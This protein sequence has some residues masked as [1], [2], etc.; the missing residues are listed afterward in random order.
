MTF[1]LGFSILMALK[2]VLFFV[3]IYIFIPS[4]IVRFRDEETF[5][6]KFFISLV[7]SSVI[8]IIIVHIL[9]FLKLYETFSLFFAYGIWYIA[10]SWVRGKS[11]VAVADALGMKL[12]VNILDMSE[13]RSGLAGEL[14]GRAKNWLYQVLAFIKNIVSELFLNPF[15]GVFPFAAIAAAAVIRFNHSIT[16]AYYGASDSYVHLAWIKYLG[17]NQMYRDGIYSYGYHAV[18]SALSKITLIDPYFVVRFIGPLAGTLLVLSVYYFASRNFKGPYV[19]LVAVL[20]YGMVTDDR[21]PNEVW[22]QISALPQEYAA[23]FLLPGL[24]FFN[25]WLKN[26]ANR[27]LWLSA[28]CLAI[29]IYIHPYVTVF[30]SLGCAVMCLCYP[31]KLSDIRFLAKTITAFIIAFLAGMFPVAVGILTG[32]EFHSTLGYIKQDLESSGQAVPS[33]I[34]ASLSED[35]PFILMML[36]SS[37]IL[38]LCWLLNGARS[39]MKREE[40]AYLFFSIISLILYLFYRVSSTGILVVM[41]PHRIATFMAVFS[42]ITYAGTV[43]ALDLIRVKNVFNALKGVAVVAVLT[44]ILI[45]TPVKVPKGE[46][47]EYDEAVNAYL[48]IKNSFPA[49]SWTIVAP[50][51][52]YQQT[53][54]YAWHVE[55]LEFVKK[56][57]AARKPEGDKSYAIPTDYVFIFTEK[58]P[59]GSDRHVEESDLNA[60]IPELKGTETEFYYRNAE[61]RRILQAKAFFWAEDYMKKRDNMEVFFEGQYLKIFVLKQDYR[62]PVKL[63]S[64]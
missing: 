38:L 4:Q 45:F 10:Y 6:D 37:A 14:A 62:N 42:A 13:G 16:H 25:L 8:T 35:N 64:D 60:E 2:V 32:K 5:L 1:G 23:I 48:K 44:A 21:F 34:T 61:N 17:A 63:F 54:G 56:M 36:A 30:L 11:P 55:L 46:C 41:D 39:G 22:R 31:G 19:A 24:H 7:H 59:L 53:L 29:T 27:Y 18:L 58:I 12:V 15:A 33:Q 57:E 51:E 47:F 20:I 43:N 50:V 3:F 49:L 52:Q 28:E 40:R 26:P 9:A